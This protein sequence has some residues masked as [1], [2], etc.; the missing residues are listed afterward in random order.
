MYVRTSEEENMFLIEKSGIYFDI[1]VYG[2][3]L[4]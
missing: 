2:D 4:L 3:G 1:G